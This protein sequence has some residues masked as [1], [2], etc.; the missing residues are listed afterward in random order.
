MSCGSSQPGLLGL[1]SQDWAAA[2]S[3]VPQKVPCALRGISGRLPGGLWLFGFWLQKYQG[4]M[5]TTGRN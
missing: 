5:A 2:A 1:P 4:A 3:R